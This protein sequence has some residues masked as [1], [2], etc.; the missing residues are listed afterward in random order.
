METRDLPLLDGLNAAAYRALETAGTR[1][2][3]AGEFLWHAGDPAAALYIVLSG[4]VRV[5]RTTG[6]R[7]RV[8]HTEKRGGTLGD[9]ALFAGSPYPATAQ[10]V[11]HVVTLALTPDLV[12]R[13]IAADPL[14]ASRLLQRLAQRVREVIGRFDQ[15]SESVTSRVARFLLTRHERAGAASFTLGMTQQQLAE[16]LGT[17]REVIVRVLRELRA[18]G[19]LA[20]PARGRYQVLDLQ[21]LRAKTLL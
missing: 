10:A 18:E 2:F 20:T 16:E 9:V 15:T 7:Q 17:A 6:D 14:F 12:Q 4:E 8:V 3:A 21:A 13:V 19:M 11:S 1:R 5:L